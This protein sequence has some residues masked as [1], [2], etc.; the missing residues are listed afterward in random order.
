M[1]KNAGTLF[2]HVWWELANFQKNWLQCFRT[3]P[4]NLLT[5]QVSSWVFLVLFNCTSIW[6][7]SCLQGAWTMYANSLARP[8]TKKKVIWRATPGGRLFQYAL[9][10]EPVQYSTNSSWVAAIKYPLKCHELPDRWSQTDRESYALV[11]LYT[12]YRFTASVINRGAKYVCLPLTLPC[13]WLEEAW[14]N[15]GARGCFILNHAINI[16]TNSW[17][18]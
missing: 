10:L 18:L 3:V 14:T 8:E 4:T 15:S 9:T 2:V 16:H 7:K 12:D 17:K 5:L 1:G 11:A 13:S 6:E